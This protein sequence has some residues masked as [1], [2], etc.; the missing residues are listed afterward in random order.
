MYNKKLNIIEYY[1]TWHLY[2]TF[3][4]LVFN[5]WSLAEINNFPLSLFIAISLLTTLDGLLV[6]LERINLGNKAL[7][8]CL[9]SLI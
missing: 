6:D 8:P 7:F 3:I 1:S 4:M 5:E 9:H 2:G